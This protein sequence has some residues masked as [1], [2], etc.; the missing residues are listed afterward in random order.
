MLSLENLPSLACRAPAIRARL[1][2]DNVT[3]RR[4]GR[5]PVARVR[6]KEAGR[7]ALVEHETT[8]L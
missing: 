2:A 4:V 8:S 3:K 5:E 6:I 7:K 1:A